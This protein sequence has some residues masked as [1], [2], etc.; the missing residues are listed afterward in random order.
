[1][2]LSDIIKRFGYTHSVT[3]VILLIN[4]FVRVSLV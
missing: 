1:M 4:E 2:F 3:Y